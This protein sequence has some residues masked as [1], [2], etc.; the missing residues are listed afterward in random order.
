MYKKEEAK[1]P[2]FTAYNRLY[3]QGPAQS[4]ALLRFLVGAPP[5]GGFGRAGKR[6]YC[7]TNQGH[8]P[9]AAW[10]RLRVRRIQPE[11]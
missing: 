7:S 3:A 4:L 10:W 8:I 5:V 9:S 1:Y 2:G 11:R 6:I